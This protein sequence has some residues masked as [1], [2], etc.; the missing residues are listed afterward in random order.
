MCF[1]KRIG[2]VSSFR[3]VSEWTHL[4]LSGFRQVLLGGSLGRDPGSAEEIRSLSWPGNNSESDWM[5]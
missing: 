4:D 3:S 5:R 1:L 2:G